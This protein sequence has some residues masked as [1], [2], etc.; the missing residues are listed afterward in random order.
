MTN[1][2]LAPKGSIV[3]L[4]TPFNDDESINFDKI[5]QLV[6]YHIK[7]KTDAIAILG[8]TGESPTISHIEEEEIVKHVVKLAKGKIPIIVGSG[9]N[10]TKQAVKSSQRYEELGADYLMV[11]T[12]Y[13]NRT[14][15]MGMI[16][17][18]ES[19]ANNVNTGIIMYNVPARTGCNISV[20]SVDVLSKHKNI[21]GIK[22]ASGD[23]SYVMQISK[24]VSKDFA[25]YTGNDDII[26][27]TL[28]V[29]GTGV[30]SVWA[31]FMPCE[32]RDLVHAYLNGEREKSLQIQQNH[33]NL[34][35]YLFVETNPIPVKYV[36]NKLGFGVGPFRMPLYEL[37]KHHQNNMDELLKNFDIQKL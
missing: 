5:T 8:T 21:I 7:H 24:Y 10:E 33:L 27:P 3:A 30:V 14:N 20:K 32:V 17:H 35:N 29:G 15:E 34:I 18:F 26:V 13:Y 2:N 25:L 23:F 28:S 19:I 37:S 22:E 4:V 11:L 9:S 36:M 31:N 1:K 12:P 6:E 16:K